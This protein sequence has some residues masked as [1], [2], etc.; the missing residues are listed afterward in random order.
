MEVTSVRDSTNILKSSKISVPVNNEQ[1]FYLSVQPNVSNY[2]SL[3]LQSR[4]K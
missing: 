2:K 3:Y 4:I 1:D